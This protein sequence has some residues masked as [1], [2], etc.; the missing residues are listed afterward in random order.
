MGDLACPT[1]SLQP[2]C[3]AFIT[4]TSRSASVPRIGTLPQV[5]VATRGSPSR[6]PGGQQHPFR[7]AIRIETTDSPVPCQGLQRAHATFTPDTTRATS[8]QLPGSGHA[9][10]RVLIPRKACSLGFDVIVHI[11]DASAVVH[12]CS[13]SH[14]LP[15]P[16]VAGLLRS[17][18][19]PR[20]LT[21]MTLRRFGISAC[22]ANPEG[23]PPSLA[24]HGS[25]WRPSTSSS[26]S[27]Q[28]TPRPEVPVGG[29]A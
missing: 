19:P 8:R 29:T 5:A 12:T 18:F 7:L 13:Y 14:R 9:E 20:L 15:D 17:R 11:H 6:R 1:P 10:R 21:G 25:C 23:L 2:H 24:Q 3:S 22:T 26:R 16:L 28:D 4:T 27:F